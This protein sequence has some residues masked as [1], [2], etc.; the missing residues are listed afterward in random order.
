ME[1]PSVQLFDRIQTAKNLPSLPQILLRLIELCNSEASQI[2]DISDIIN[3]DTSLSV[4]VMSMANSSY[5]GRSKRVT[6]IEQALSI[7]GKNTIKNIAIGAA[8]IQAFSRAEDTAILGLKVFWRHSLMCAVLSRLIAKKI[9]YPDPDEAF[10]AGLLHDIGKLVLWVNFPEEY[11]A[12]FRSSQYRPDLISAEKALHDATHCDVGAWLIRRWDRQSFMADA[13]LYHH[14][15]LERIQDALPLIK[16]I[17]VGNS[18]CPETNAEKTVKFLIA[19]TIIGLEMSEVEEI[20]LQAEGE[21]RSTAQ[22]LGLDIETLD[23]YGREVSDNDHKKQTD[24][25]KE[26]Q[27]VA[28]LQGTLQD[29]LEAR[30]EDSILQV[31]QQGFDILFDVK[32]TFFFLYESASNVL[33]GKNVSANQQYDIINTVTIPFQK[34]KSF[35]IKSLLWGEPLDSFSD[36]IKDHHTIIDE[37][38]IRLAAK[39]GILCLPMAAY[40]QYMGVIVL[41]LTQSRFANLTTKMRLLLMFTKQA[42]L[43][44][45]ANCFRP[46][47]AKAVPSERPDTPST[48]VRKVAHEVNTPLSIVK[49]YLA[50]LKSKLPEDESC[51]EEIRIINEE[52]NSVAL[53]IRELAEPSEL[54]VQPNAPLDLNV[55]LSGLIRILQESLMLA[56]DI[57]AHLKLDPSL[58]KVMTDKSKMKQ[59]FRNLI[60]NAAEAMPEGGNLNIRTRHVFNY[61]DATMD[62]SIDSTLGHAEITIRDEGP[63]LVDTVRSSLF[64]PYVTSKGTGH[65]GLGLSITYNHVKELKGSITCEDDNKKGAG[66]K[67]V[68]PVTHSEASQP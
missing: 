45:H 42:A 48:M 3:I 16:I 68:F 38:I 9:L 63:G 7:L 62:S 36:S 22:S 27:D 35:L 11:A 61:I 18:L 20:A 8:D 53:M 1:E 50:V 43:A 29:L 60:M 44:L 17:Y 23:G 5:Y 56:P 66:F 57:N 52:I 34:E 12:I 10:L 21:V 49:N 55:F 46:S 32:Q 41:G 19:K 30:D 4:K 67:I 25:I 65:A 24:L 2:K 26:L 51:Q 39:D 14:E 15:S 6:N 13:I 28:L 58:P 64:E 31:V 33:F 37:Q 47:Q 54:K 40:Q 59:V